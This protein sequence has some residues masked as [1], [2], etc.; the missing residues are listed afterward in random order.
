[1]SASW[2]VQRVLVAQL[3]ADSTFMDLIS[4]RLYDEPPT[5]EDYPYVVVGDTVETPD[6][7]LTYNGYDTSLSFTIKTKPGGLG[8]ATA[9]E[10][11]NAM[12]NVLNMKKFDMT[13][14]TMI[15]CKF[16]NMITNRDG[17]IRSIISR[18]QVISDTET[19]IKFN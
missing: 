16:D 9:K 17:D 2:E 13:G 5:N 11:L 4:N 3:S 7:S 15:I 19:V 6:N 14:F 1:M 8:F 12:N 10:I 18:Y